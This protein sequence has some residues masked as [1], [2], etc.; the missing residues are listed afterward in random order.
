M[1]LAIVTGTSR[2]IGAAVARE[3]TARGWSVMGCARGPAAD[4]LAGAR[5]HHRELDLSD[6]AAVEEWFEGEFLAV[7]RLAEAGRVGLV[8][9][10][11]VLACSLVRDVDLA[12]AA[13]ALSVNVAVPVWLTGLVLRHAPPCPV[14]VVDL[15]SGAATS[16]VAGWAT[17]CASKAALHM[18]G[19]VLAAE[20]EQAPGLAGRD[21][22]VVSYAPNVVDTA[23]QDELRAL[24]A[25]SFPRREEFV[26]MKREG[27][28]VQAAGPAREIADLLER[29]GLP[30]HSTL[31]FEP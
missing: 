5:Y 23:M 24:G 10:A 13:R 11:A 15:S 16:P 27:L 6:A 26:A 22:R 21:L 4:G 14:R 31:R 17:Y 25:G 19:E 9:N 29:E 30:P 7:S 3:L 28:L 1:N 2:G 20:L 8:N 18:A 12:T